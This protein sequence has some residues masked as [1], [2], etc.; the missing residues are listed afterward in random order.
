MP[1]AAGSSNVA[2]ARL[3]SAPSAAKAPWWARTRNRGDKLRAI[4]FERI[5]GGKPFNPQ[6]DSFVRLLKD[7]G[8]PISAPV[9]V[10]HY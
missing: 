7:I 8:Q 4:K 1:P 6:T 10:K 9:E 3:R 5:K 2:P